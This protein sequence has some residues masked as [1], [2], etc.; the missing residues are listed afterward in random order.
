MK[1]LIADDSATNLKLLDAQL[2]AEQII[3]LQ[4][5]NGIEALEILEQESVDVIISDILMPKMDGYALCQNVRSQEKFDSVVFIFYTA[6]YASPADEQFAFSLGADAFFK[7]PSPVNAILEGIESLRDNT[8][9]RMRPRTHLSDVSVLREYSDRL[10][11][12]LEEK[13]I[14]L[15]QRTE[16]LEHEIVQRKQE[17]EKRHQLER[18]LIQAQKLES[19]GT[20]AS[21]IAHDFNNILGIILGHSSLIQRDQSEPAKLAQSIEAIQKATYRGASVVKQLL[22]FARKT[23][24]E[25]TPAIINDIINEITKL[26]SETFP[27]TIVLS[28]NLKKDLPSTIADETQIHQ[29][30]L[31]LFV[32]ARDA[33]PDGGTLTI[34]TNIVDGRALAMIFPKAATAQYILI[35]VVD[36]GGGMDETTKRRIF[37]PFF[38][39]KGRAKGTGLGLSVVYGIIESHQGFIDVASEVGKGTTFRVYLP[40]QQQTVKNNIAP[41]IEFKDVPGGAETV[42]LIEDEEMLRELVK[43]VLVSKG[44]TVLTAVDGE[45]GISVFSRHQNNISTVVSDMGLPKLSG[46]EVCKTIMAINPKAKIILASGFVELDMKS[47]LIKVGVSRFIRKPYSP[48]EILQTVRSVIDLTNE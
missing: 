37:E 23:E 24:A 36:T 46:Q 45:E 3:V 11:A 6:T 43:V 25:F 20:L 5:S 38:T 19:L 7:K 22:T 10:V 18:Q 42:L 1:I 35:E 33:M 17:E 14:E 4:A 13:N 31:N 32:N 8:S 40:V 30:L 44:Y 9:Q 28:I 39:T 21:G 16:E 12:K 48:E 29:V 15:L 34:T 2:E 41:K 47:E 27:K 26:L